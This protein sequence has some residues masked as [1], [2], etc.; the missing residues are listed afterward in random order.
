[1]DRLKRAALMTRLLQNLK[2]KGSWCGET[3][4]QKAT[5]FVQHLMDVP[6]GFE[7]ILYKH[8]PFSFDLRDELTSLR[9]DRLIR[10]VPRWPYGP[11]IMPTELAKKLQN[12]Y[13]RTLGLYENKIAYVADKLGAKGVADLERLATAFYVTRQQ[14]AGDPPE[15]R[16]AKLSEI[17][18]HISA[19]QALAAIREVDQMIEESQKI[20]H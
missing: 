1:M 8:G 15:K 13:Q 3:H 7:F 9:A 4:T 14:W 17:K 16:A 10:L 18:P 12:N 6:L 5:F 2:D 11:T 20:L 19:D